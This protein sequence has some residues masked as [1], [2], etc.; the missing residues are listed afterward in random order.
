MSIHLSKK[1]KPSSGT[2]AMISSS[3]SNTTKRR[4]QDAS[5]SFEH[6]AA[7]E[8]AALVIQRAWR[9]PVDPMTLEPIVGKPFVLISKEP[10]HTEFKFDACV[11]ANYFDTSMDFI[12]PLTREEL[13]QVEV[14]RLS[15]HPMVA[16]TVSSPRAPPTSD[17]QARQA[18][19]SENMMKTYESRETLKR[20]I[21]ASTQTIE[22]MFEELAYDINQRLEH[23]VLAIY[24]KMARSTSK[25]Y[26]RSTLGVIE[27]VSKMHQDIEEL[28]VGQLDLTAAALVVLRELP[29]GVD[30][31]QAGSNVLD[32]LIMI[33]HQHSTITVTHKVLYRVV[34]KSIINA[35]VQ[36]ITIMLYN[37]RISADILHTNCETLRKNITK[38]IDASSSEKIP[39]Y[40]TERV[41][42]FFTKLLQYI[43]PERI[44]LN[45]HSYYEPKEFSRITA[46]GKRVQLPPPDD[47]LYV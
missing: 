29:P 1:R 39:H 19:I 27:L 14:L 9:K 10:P 5:S 24:E 8:A 35:C 20:D 45:R 25:F 6:D 37:P 34:F 16:R 15:K 12:N 36:A 41:T 32:L 26:G 7:V 28:N 2:I 17:M 46:S 23:M 3:P 43:A 30:L 22:L 21:A 33:S 40:L 13:N 4:K 42:S 47:I 18:W 38:K 44:E 11:L 31:F